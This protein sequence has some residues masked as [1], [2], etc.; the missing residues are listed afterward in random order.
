[1]DEAVNRG[2]DI[3][4]SGTSSIDLT[5]ALLKH[6]QKVRGEE[7]SMPPTI[8]AFSIFI[9]PRIMGKINVLSR[10]KNCEYLKIQRKI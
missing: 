5:Q 1:M 4:D 2:K 9:N 7:Q 6:T 3:K 8:P 10:I